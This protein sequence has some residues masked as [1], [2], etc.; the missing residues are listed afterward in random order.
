MIV[1]PDTSVWIEFLKRRDPYFG[2][3]SAQIDRVA[4]FE[5]I[6]GELLQGVRNDRERRIIEEIWNTVPHVSVD[7][8][9]IRAGIRSSEKSYISQ[10]VG[11]IDCAILLAAEENDLFIA[12]IDKKFMKIIPD[13]LRYSEIGN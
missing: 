3:I 5:P 12:T 2:I 10:G 1:L 11:L 13:R 6:F 4:G 9:W 8:I 7:H